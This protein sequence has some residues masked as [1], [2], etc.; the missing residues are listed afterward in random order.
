MKEFEDIYLKKDDN[1]KFA[2]TKR[3]V[4]AKNNE[5]MKNICNKYDFNYN[6][7]TFNTQVHGSDVIFINDSCSNFEA[8]GLITNLKGVP[9]LVFTADCVPVI[10]Y[11]KVVGVIGVVHAGWRGT[12][13]S[14]ASKMIKDLVAYGSDINNI[15]TVIGPSISGKNYEV[16]KE[17]VEKFAKLEVD[18]FYSEK[19][20]KYF[21]DLW[22]INK[23][24]L[25]KSGVKEE[26]I[27]IMN[28]CTVG[29]NDKFF[30]YRMD[31]ATA[32]RIGT[33]IQID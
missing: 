22:Q 4:D 9:L 14:I 24:Q 2:F 18:N 17:L 32:K 31:N 23:S 13:A 12:Y 29:D 6:S 26:N 3:V 30:S 19:G 11:D 28:M 25:L 20:G 27:K 15:K 1:I 21:L 10:F 7:L 33:L 16:S 8:D 5:D